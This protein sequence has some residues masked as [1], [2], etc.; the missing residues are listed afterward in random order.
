MDIGHV[1]TGM[2]SHVRAAVGGD[3]AVPP[4][5]EGRRAAAAASSSPTDEAQTAFTVADW[6]AAPQSLAWLAEPRQETT[7]SAQVTGMPASAQDTGDAGLTDS[8]WDFDGDSLTS[9]PSVPRPPSPADSSQAQYSVGFSSQVSGQTTLGE[10]DWY[11]SFNSDNDG[12]WDSSSSESQSS[13]NT[14]C[15]TAFNLDN[16]G[17]RDGSSSERSSYGTNIV[18]SWSNPTSSTSDL[19][20]V[21][22]DGQA[23]IEQAMQELAKCVS[24]GQLD[25]KRRGCELAERLLHE[26]DFDFQRRPWVFE[27]GEVEP[28]V[29]REEGAVVYKRAEAGRTPPDRWK[30]SGGKVGGAVWPRNGPAP[31]RVRCQYGMVHRCSETPQSHTCTRYVM[32]TLIGT[33]DLPEG[34]AQNLHLD[35]RLYVAY[36]SDPERKTTQRTAPGPDP[37]QVQAVSTQFTSLIESLE[38]QGRGSSGTHAPQL[39][40]ED[41]CSLLRLVD[42]RP[43]EFETACGGEAHRPYVLGDSVGPR[44]S[45]TRHIYIETGAISAKKRRNETMARRRMGTDQQ[46]D[47]WINRGGKKAIVY[48]KAGDGTILERR[49]GRIEPI[50]KSTERTTGSHSQA[51]SGLFFFRFTMGMAKED[52]VSLVARPSVYCV[53][54]KEAG[55]LSQKRRSQGEGTGGLKRKA[56][57]PLLSSTTSSTPDD[58]FSGQGKH[59]N[60]RHKLAAAAATG[61]SLV[62]LVCI[63]YMHLV[64]SKGGPPLAASGSTR[65]VYECAAVD[66]WNSSVDAN[67][68]SLRVHALKHERLCRRSID[69]GSLTCEVDFA[70]GGKAAGACN[71]VCGLNAIDVARGPGTCAAIIASGNATCELEFGPGGQFVGGCE[72]ECANCAPPPPPSP[73]NFLDQ[74]DLDEDYVGTCRKDLLT[75]STLSCEV[76]FSYGGKYQGDCD[77]T[78]G[79]N[80]LDSSRGAGMCAKYL[81]SGQWSCEHDFGHGEKYESYC[82]FACGLRPSSAPAAGNLQD[83]QFIRLAAQLGWHV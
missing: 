26:N 17:E 4:H 37:V 13:Y 36:T 72:F 49:A 8:M 21:T 12:E 79:F 48:L 65:P 60:R 57:V 27:D 55:S 11:S 9:S 62:A 71:K 45:L 59:P 32:Y 61:L 38:S 76:D 66:R 5:Q 81:A 10:M 15:Y 39:D 70:F 16:D 44:Q 77:H 29:F 82:D 14:S 7:A 42:A 25:E 53:Y 34:S 68:S 74:R 64:V 50:D 28:A 78:C 23:S 83:Y 52:G 75:S 67:I 69:Q 31:A 18:Q 63:G 54:T 51:G 1:S 80:W 30:S 6:G 3:R 2:D 47:K 22:H 24:S 33:G 41:V 58:R 43:V 56:A 35:R 46:P 19:W 20:H 40:I 73:C